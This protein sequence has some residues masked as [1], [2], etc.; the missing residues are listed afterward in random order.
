MLALTTLD[1][2]ARDRATVDLARTSVGLAEL[3][4]SIRCDRVEELFIDAL[5]AGD[6]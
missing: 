6:G 4:P 5:R 1:P 2:A 3:V